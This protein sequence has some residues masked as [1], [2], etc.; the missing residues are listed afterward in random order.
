[1][2]AISVAPATASHNLLANPDFAAGIAGW[3]LEPGPG[4]VDMA[5]NPDDGFPEPGALRISGTQ[6]GPTFTV[7]EALSECF[8]VTPGVPYVLRG[9]VLAEEGVGGTRCLPYIVRY[10]DP[11]CGGERSFLGGNLTPDEPGVWHETLV[12]NDSNFPSLRVALAT[13]AV[14][15][16]GPVACNFDS[17]VL[18]QQGTEE[19]LEVPV[20]T[21]A[22][23]VFLAATLALAALWLLQRLG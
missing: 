3:T 18:F 23:Q 11:A 14:V 21:P 5:W 9:H 17:I 13:L 8:D 19:P 12:V 20:N 16:E 2:S 15:G 10:T 4:V 6:G 22:G 1:M 7:G